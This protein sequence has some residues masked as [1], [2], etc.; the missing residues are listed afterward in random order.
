MTGSILKDRKRHRR[1]VDGCRAPNQTAVGPWRPTCGAPNRLR[2][3]N[4]LIRDCGMDQ[5]CAEGHGAEARMSPRKASNPLE[6]QDL[7]RACNAPLPLEQPIDDVG[8]VIGPAR[9]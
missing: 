8:G 1:N 4:G 9:R 3:F 7:R 5:A 2:D 6:C